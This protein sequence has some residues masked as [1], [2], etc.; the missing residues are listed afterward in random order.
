VGNCESRLL[1]TIGET[2]GPRSFEAFWSGVLEEKSLADEGFPSCLAE[3]WAGVCKIHLLAG[4]SKRGRDCADSVC[5]ICRDPCQGVRGALHAPLVSLGETPGSQ[6][7]PRARSTKA[8]PCAVA[9]RSASSIAK[10]SPSFMNE[11]H[12]RAT[13]P[14]YWAKAINPTICCG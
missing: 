8:K 6:K 14:H 2:L 13:R 11:R 4:D 1:R 10:F 5:T 7:R 12:S 3:S 9:G